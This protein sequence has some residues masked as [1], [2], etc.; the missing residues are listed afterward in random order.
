ML[1][2]THIIAS[3][4]PAYVLTGNLEYGLLASIFGTISDLDTILREFSCSERMGI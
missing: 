4:T 2:K 1:K 3:F